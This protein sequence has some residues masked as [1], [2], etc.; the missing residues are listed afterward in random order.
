[1]AWPTWSVLA[2]A[3]WRWGAAACEGPRTRACWSRV[4][5]QGG[6]VPSPRGSQG[7]PRGRRR[8]ENAVRGP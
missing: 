7:T 8:C 5:A 4:R 1:M 2:G 3:D 6:R